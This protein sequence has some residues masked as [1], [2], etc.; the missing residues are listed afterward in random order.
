MPMTTSEVSNVCNNLDYKILFDS[1]RNIKHVADSNLGLCDN[2]DFS[3]L[4]PDWKGPGW[5]RLIFMRA[6]YNFVIQKNTYK[7]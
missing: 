3:Y 5:Y 6:N 2:F 1:T 7:A 4:S